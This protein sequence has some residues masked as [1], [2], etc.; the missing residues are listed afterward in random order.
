MD[1]GD[2]RLH[3]G[4]QRQVVHFFEQ[5]C[6]QFAAQQFGMGQG[7][8]VKNRIAFAACC[9]QAGLGQDL[10]VVAHA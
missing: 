8:T 1:L 7:A 5:G 9:H 6:V 10:E 2:A 4:W 3:F